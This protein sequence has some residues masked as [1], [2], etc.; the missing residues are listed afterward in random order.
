[1]VKVERPGGDPLL[2]VGQADGDVPLWWK[3]EGRNKC[4]VDELLGLETTFSAAL[5]GGTK[6]HVLELG[7]VSPREG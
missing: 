5:R 1:M 4:K 7:R 2:Q 3:A 6:E